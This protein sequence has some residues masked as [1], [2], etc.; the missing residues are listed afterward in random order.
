M[1]SVGEAGG[2]GWWERGWSMSAGRLGTAGGNCEYFWRGF[3]LDPTFSE[4]HPDVVPAEPISDGSSPIQAIDDPRL[5]LIQDTG[6][7][8]LNYV[9]DE[10]LQIRPV[11]IFIACFVYIL[12]PWSLIDDLPDPCLH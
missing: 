7:P 11:L 3:R 2:Y 6:G 8:R 9:A 12:C 1:E 10:P 4:S 5:L